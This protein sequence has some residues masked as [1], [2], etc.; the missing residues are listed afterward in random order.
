MTTTYEQNANAAFLLTGYGMG[1]IS[2]VLTLLNFERED[3]AISKLE[4][5]QQY[6]KQVLS[7]TIYALPRN[8]PSPERVC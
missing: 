4:E 1:V 7:E 5:A 2:D 8:N 3:E 6:F